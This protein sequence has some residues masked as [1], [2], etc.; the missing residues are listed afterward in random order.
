MLFPDLP[1]AA[2]A[3]GGAHSRRTARRRD[4]RAGRVGR[5]PRRGARS[6]TSSC[7][8]PASI[9]ASA[10]SPTACA[11]ASCPA[12]ATVED[13][14]RRFRH[15]PHRPRRG[16]GARAR[17]RLHRPAAGAARAAAS[18]LG[19]RQPEEL[20]RPARHLH[21]PDHRPRAELRPRRARLPRTAL[22]RDRAAHLQR[23][24]AHRHAAQPAPLPPRVGA[25]VGERRRARSST[26][27]ARLVDCDDGASATIREGLVGVTIDLEG[28]PATS[29]VG[30]K[31]RKHTPTSSTST[32]VDALRPARF[33]G[34]DPRP[35]ARR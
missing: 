29:L 19:A 16:R 5:D 27:Q 14:L 24:G 33:L 32:S 18:D 1:V 25:R 26:T 34:A 4:P 8:R 10:T 17:L 11:R 35:A 28:D 3:P 13:K 6:P 30:F 7:S 21:A 20:D 12:P 31:A 22:R 23:P 2:Q 9:C 15:A